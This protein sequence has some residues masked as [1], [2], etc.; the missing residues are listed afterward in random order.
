VLKHVVTATDI[1]HFVAML[2]SPL[3]IGVHGEAIGIDG[4]NRSD[5]HY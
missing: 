3:A 1:G 2:C 4:G 5:M